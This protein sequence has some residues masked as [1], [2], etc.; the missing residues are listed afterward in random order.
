MNPQHW[1]DIQHLPVEYRERTCV[2]EERCGYTRHHTPVFVVS[3]ARV[4]E[5]EEGFSPEPAA[6]VAAGALS[7]STATEKLVLMG[8]GLGASGVFPIPFELHINPICF[9]ALS[10]FFFKI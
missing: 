1:P 4:W 3:F 5:P 6:G 8:V 9:L 10:L 2:K 7:S